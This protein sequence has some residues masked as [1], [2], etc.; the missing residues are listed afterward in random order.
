[1]TPYSDLS[2]T[3]GQLI[4]LGSGDVGTVVAVHGVPSSTASV[5]FSDGS[6]KAV[7]FELATVRII[8]DEGFLAAT[9]RRPAELR[10]LVCEQP[11]SIVRLVLLDSVDQT[12]ETSEIRRQLVPGWIAE[13]EWEKWW[14]KTREILKR[15][16]EFDTSQARK[17]VYAL[18]SEQRRRQD[19]LLGKLGS[20]TESPP[21]R[22]RYLK[23]LLEYH[24][25]EPLS[26]DE[27]RL[28]RT[29]ILWLADSARAEAWVRVQ[30]L[31]LATGFGW[32]D[33]DSFRASIRPIAGQVVRWRPITKL[34]HFQM[35]LGALLDSIAR[36]DAVSPG[37]WSGL[38]VVPRLGRWLVCQM[39]ALYSV[40]QGEQ[41]I[42]EAFAAAFPPRPPLDAEPGWILDLV[43]VLEEVRSDWRMFDPIHPLNWQRLAETLLACVTR[44]QPSDLERERATPVAVSI[45]RTAMLWL[46]G[47]ASDKVAM[48]LARMR[49]AGEGFGFQLPLFVEA[50]L[51]GDDETMKAA[52]V[53]QLT[54]QQESTAL[55]LIPTKFERQSAAD[56]LALLDSIVAIGPTRLAGLPLLT[57]RTL[58]QCVR[59]ADTIEPS[60]KPRLLAIVQKANA[61]RIDAHRSVIALETKLWYD[62]LLNSKSGNWPSLSEP[63]SL[64]PAF[65]AAIRELLDDAREEAETQTAQMRQ[66]R[67]ALEQASSK[68]RDELTQL[69]ARHGEL[70]KNFRTDQA[71]EESSTRPDE[72]LRGLA[73]VLAEVERASARQGLRPEAAGQLLLAR[74]QRLVKQSGLVPIAHMGQMV[75]FDPSQHE[76]VEGSLGPTR[77]VEIL[78]TGYYQSKPD[79][80]HV[81][82]KPALVRA[83]GV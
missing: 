7:S 11:E 28:A 44:L 30:A 65:R 79:G 78:E 17:Q 72:T 74:L 62:I 21:E 1:M 77:Q 29:Q 27:L 66:E 48:T 35:A 64:S 56:Q 41:A 3:P 40:S 59:V 76:I 9:L 24:R 34:E 69:T 36:D 2:P 45:I 19:E 32:I 81:V 22:M 63:Y 15:H 26:E 67:D 23:E 53:E 6:T 20:A 8:S 18:R 80:T 71:R 70:K 73:T 49:A 55:L 33:E 37:I 82:L 46:P 43:E 57:A 10:R 12:L 25:R 52:L 68:T 83:I 39:L 5:R 75:T 13:Q 58:A 47:S 60:E 54:A 38:L 31:V 14:S 42:A 61:A 51:E 4:Q 16:P 50:V